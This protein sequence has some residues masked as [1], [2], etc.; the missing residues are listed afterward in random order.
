[1]TQGT[2]RNLATKKHRKHKIFRLL[3]HAALTGRCRSGGSVDPD[4]RINSPIRVSADPCPRS[5]QHGLPFES[6]Y[7]SDKICVNRRQSAV[8]FSVSIP[9]YPCPSVFIRGSFPSP[10]FLCVYPWCS[11]H[12]PPV[13]PRTLPTA[14]VLGAAFSID[15]NG[16]EG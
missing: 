5:G 9:V 2:G 12:A 1:M 8:S 14:E 4:M 3:T 7:I 13:R 15:F 11:S 16:W 10:A 6:S